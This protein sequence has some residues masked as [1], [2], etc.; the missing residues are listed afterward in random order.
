MTQAPTF[1]VTFDAPNVSTAVVTGPARLPLPDQPRF[2]HCSVLVCDRSSL[3]S[4]EGV[5]TQFPMERDG[6]MDSGVAFDQ[7]R[8]DEH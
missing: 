1:D 2:Q 6:G 4:P 8:D 7:Q 5:R 3:Q